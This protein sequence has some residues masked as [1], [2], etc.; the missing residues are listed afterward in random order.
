MKKPPSIYVQTDINTTMEELWEHTQN[1]DL[2]TQ[3]DVRFTE[4]SYLERK[5]NEPQRFLYRTQIGMGLNIAGEGESVGQVEKESGDRV[6]SLKF[7]TENRLSLIKSGR[8]YW[9][10]TQKD[11]KIGFETLYNYDPAFGKPGRF[12]DTYLFRPMLSWATAWSF[13]ALKMWLEKGFHPR[14]LLQRFLT[15]WMVCVLISFVWIYLGLVPKVIMAH[16][17]EIRMMTS[18]TGEMADGPL[19]IRIVGI[20]EMM[21]GLVWLLPLYRLKRGVFIFHIVAICGLTI[22]AGIG[23]IRSFVAPFNPVTL[24]VMLIVVSIIGYGNSHDLPS[25]FNC[26]RRKTGEL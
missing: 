6:S 7:W 20:L 16:P 15:Y 2:H 14:L 24:N 19:M 9:K 26:R 8:G 12:I 22:S 5:E 1:P 4:I 25:A 17:D 21:F 10:Y 23:D 18:L 13:D 11:G 3:W